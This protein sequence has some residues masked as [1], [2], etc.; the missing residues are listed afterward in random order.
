MLEVKPHCTVAAI[1][2]NKSEEIA[3]IEKLQ[4]IQKLQKSLKAMLIPEQEVKV[5]A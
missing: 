2:T 5:A 3:R 4:E 1:V